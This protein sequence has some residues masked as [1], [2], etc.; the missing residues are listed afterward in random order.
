MYVT[1]TSVG[2]IVR[3]PLSSV[4][5]GAEVKRELKGRFLQPY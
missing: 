5:P 3:V 2:H 1:E 4:L